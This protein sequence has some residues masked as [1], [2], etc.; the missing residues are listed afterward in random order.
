MPYIFSTLREDIDLFQGTRSH[1]GFPTYVLHDRWRNRFFNIGWLEYEILKRWHL[2]NSEE[3]AQAVCEETTLYAAVEDVEALDAFLRS[4]EIVIDNESDQGTAA[5]IESANKLDDKKRKS[6]IKLNPMGY[7]SLRIPLIRPD[8][9]LDST[10]WMVK[11]L[12]TKTAFYIYCVLLVFA[13]I[14]VLQQWHA[15]QSY[16][17][18]ALSWEGAIY[19]FLALAVSKSFH[20]FGHA[21]TAKRLGLRVPSMGLMWMFIFGFLYTDTTESWKLESRKHR[22]AIGAAGVMAELQLAIIASLLWTVLPD[23]GFRYGCFYLATAA[24]V[25]TLMINLSPFLRW[26]GYWVLSDMVGIQNLRERSGKLAEWFFGKIIMGFKDEIPVKLPF[27]QVRFSIIF[28]ILAYFYRIGIFLGIGLLIFSRVFK[29]LGIFLLCSM[30]VKMILWPIIGTVIKWFKRRSD[31]HW[32][33]YSITSFVVIFAVILMLIIPWRST[34]QTPALIAP[35]QHIEV[36]PGVDGQVTYIAEQGQ[37]VSNGDILFEMQNPKL[38]SELEYE[39]NNVLYHQF[40]LQRTGSKQLL[41]ERALEQERLQAANGRYY[42]VYREMQKL[43]A[44][45]PYDGQVIWV[46]DLAK[47]NGWIR[48][49]APIMTLADTENLQMYAYI[50]EYDL[51]RLYT[52]GLVKLYADNP[53]FKPV[54][55]TILGVDSA[56]INTLDYEVLSSTNGGPI[57]AIVDQSTG[58]LKPEKPI[59]LVRIQIDQASQ[60]DLSILLLGRAI[61]QGERKSLFGRFYQSLVGTIIRESGF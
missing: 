54:T 20:E 48:S 22:V 42:K 2:R 10:L 58:K 26:D 28:A 18:Q 27:K 3:I 61:L 51:Q 38:E 47:Q 24:W 45:A 31:M 59:Y 57:Q 49:S 36:F 39:R 32:N 9:F 11:P 37:A 56:N 7:M 50:N 41:E 5:L 43:K 15:F 16:I 19:L 44:N 52:D 46:S 14:G 1:E 29:V 23:G 55:G 21:Y 25:A 17:K 30:I 34:I 33:R 60:E 4:Q 40:A 12:M 8:R 35:S 53:Y 6:R 13:I